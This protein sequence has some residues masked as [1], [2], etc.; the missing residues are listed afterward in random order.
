MMRNIGVLI[1]IVVLVIAV[2]AV[3]GSMGGA[4]GGG[5]GGIL[6]SQHT[7]N[8]VNGLITVGARNYND[9]EFTVPSGASGVSVS[10]SF[11]ASGGSGNDI[12]VLVMDST[13]F[14]NWSN[15][16]TASAYYD[17]GQ[18]TTGS[19]SASLPAGATYYLV[20]SNMFSILSSKDVQT[21]V[22]L[23]YTS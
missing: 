4:S 16:H 5:G 3:I 2:L 18:E 6:P 23:V 19:I 17:S 12:E 14:V 9:Y 7:E 10:G 8:V 13:D 20:Y 15:G 21:T 11:T 22:N 1:V